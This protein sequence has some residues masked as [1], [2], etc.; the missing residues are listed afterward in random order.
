MGNSSSTLSKGSW[1][2][3]RGHDIPLNHPFWYLPKTDAPQHLL[4]Q[5]SSVADLIDQSRGNWK[6][7][8]IPQINSPDITQQILSLPLPKLSTFETKDTIIWPH[9]HTCTYQVKKAYELLHKGSIQ[10]NTIT[11]RHHSFWKV[12]WKLKLPHKILT[13]TWKIIHHAIPIKTELNRRGIQC[14]PMCA[15]CTTSTE[16]LG[17]LFLQCAFVRAV[18]LG[19][20]IDIASINAHHIPLEQWIQHLAQQSQDTANT[21]EL[22][23]MALWCIWTH[24][25]RTIFE[26]KSPNPIETVLT[27]KSFF[28]RGLKHSTWKGIT[29]IGKTP[30]G[31]TVLAGC[32]STRLK[33]NNIAKATAVYEAASK[34]LSLGFTNILI[35]VGSK[36]L[37]HMWGN[38]YPHS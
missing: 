38:K 13:F 16:S 20:N 24:R 12:L 14:D 27:I 37:K 18:W 22:V 23:L 7:D 21:L 29:Y 25:N 9:T 4:L 31:H 11:D 32:Q 17:H 36:E 2:V 35:L 26:G 3:G 8:I 10:N 28:N 1:R 15:L 5:T 34:A 30:A 6:I 33:D 19:V